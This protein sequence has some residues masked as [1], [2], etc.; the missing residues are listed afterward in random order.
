MCKVGEAAEAEV[1]G[2]LDGLVDLQW[3]LVSN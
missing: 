1:M 2:A 3:L